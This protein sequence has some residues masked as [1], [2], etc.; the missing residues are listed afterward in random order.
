MAAATGVHP[1]TVARGKRE[2]EGL[3]EPKPRVRAPG[4][5]RKKLSETDP[6]LTAQQRK[7]L[8]ES[9]LAFREVTIERRRV[10][11]RRNGGSSS[12]TPIASV[13]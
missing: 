1:D 4:G 2:L 8:E 6:E 5:G 7:A 13:D 9:Y 11:G 10:K 3:P 12:D